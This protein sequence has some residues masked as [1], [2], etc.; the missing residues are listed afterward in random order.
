M[1]MD[2]DGDI[3]E[4]PLDTESGWST[5]LVPAT[6]LTQYTSLAPVGWSSSLTTDLFPD[7][8]SVF[9][10]DCGT[11]DDEHA[12]TRDAGAYTKW[13]SSYTH[14]SGKMNSKEHDE[15]HDGGP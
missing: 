8:G 6:L 3:A 15:K 1:L 11:T 4:S 2:L 9:D 13:W 14:I 5:D 12:R 7:M 10:L